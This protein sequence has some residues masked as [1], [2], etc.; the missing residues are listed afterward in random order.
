MSR[1]SLMEQCLQMLGS[2]HQAITARG[3]PTCCCS[4]PSELVLKIGDQIAHAGVKSEGILP[5]AYLNGGKIPFCL[6]GTQR[7]DSSLEKQSL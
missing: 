3:Q 7:L 5:K 4:T 1:E 2:P 6:A